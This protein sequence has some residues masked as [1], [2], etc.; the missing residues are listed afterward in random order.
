MH[1]SASEEP[2]AERGPGR[3]HRT[4]RRAIEQAALALFLA[5]GYEETTVDDIAT[6]ASIG[7]RTFFR[8]FASKNDVAWGE[9]DAELARLHAELDATPSEKRVLHPQRTYPDVP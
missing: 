2:P 4:T 7:R 8:Y 6:A 9:F 1:V 3:R 5:N